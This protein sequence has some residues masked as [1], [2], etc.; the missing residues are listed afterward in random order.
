MEKVTFDSVKF[1]Y[2][3][4]KKIIFNNLNFEIKKG[5]H[6]AF[7]GASGAGKSTAID[8]F[9]GLP[10]LKRK[11]LVDQTNLKNRLKK[12]EKKYKLCS[13]NPLISNMSLR[14]ILLLGSIKSS[15]IKKLLI[16]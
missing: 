1:S 10:Q 12:V 11:I 15:M 16:A 14:K 2:P 13:A 8:L 6:Y 4:S 7:I 3:N 9:L 5:F